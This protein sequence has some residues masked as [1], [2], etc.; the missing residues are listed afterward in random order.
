[1][2]AVT[3]TTPATPPDGEQFHSDTASHLG[4]ILDVEND[5]PLVPDGP[6]LLEDGAASSSSSSQQRA[7][8]PRPEGEQQTPRP[9]AQSESRAL[10]MSHQGVLQRPLAVD[11]RLKGNGPVSQKKKKASSD[12]K[13]GT[14]SS[15]K[16]APP[17]RHPKAA[18]TAPLSTG[19]SASKPAKPISGSRQPTTD[20]EKRI[21]KNFYIAL[22]K[23]VRKRKRAQLSQLRE[24]LF[25]AAAAAGVGL[26]KVEKDRDCI[27]LEEEQL[28]ELEAYIGQKYKKIR[29]F[30]EDC[31][32]WFQQDGGSSS[33]STAGGP[34]P[35]V[36]QEFR[37]PIA[38][39]LKSCDIFLSTDEDHGVEVEVSSLQ[40]LQLIPEPAR[41]DF[42]LVLVEQDHHSSAPADD[43]RDADAVATGVDVGETA[44]AQAL[45]VNE[46]ENAS[47]ARTTG[48]QGSAKPKAVAK[49]Q[50]Q[51]R[52]QEDEF[53]ENAPRR[54]G[55][56]Q[57]VEDGDEKDNQ[58]EN[59]I[60]KQKGRRK[61]RTKGSNKQ[62]LHIKE[63]QLSSV[64]DGASKYSG[65]GGGATSSSSKQAPG[66]SRGSSSGGA[67]VVEILTGGGKHLKHG[68]KLSG[69]RKTGGGYHDN[70]KQQQVIDPHY[71]WT[72]QTGADL[73]VTTT[74]G[75]EFAPNPYQFVDH[76]DINAADRST[77][78]SAHLLTPPYHD[79]NSGTT[80][81]AGPDAMGAYY[82]VPISS[83]AGSA[84]V[85]GASATAASG[86]VGGGG[87]APP[88]TTYYDTYNG[89]YYSYVNVGG[90]HVLV[91][92]RHDH[93]VQPR[94]TSTQ[95]RGPPNTGLF[96]DHTASQ[97]QQ[98]MH[99]NYP[100]LF[101]QGFQT[102]GGLMN[103]SSASSS[104]V[105]TNFRD[106]AVAST[107]QQ[108]RPQIPGSAS[109][110]AQQ[111]SNN[112]ARSSTSPATTTPSYLPHED[113]FY[114][115]A[116]HFQLPDV[117]EEADEEVPPPPPPPAFFS[118]S[119][120]ENLGQNIQRTS[121]A[122]TASTTARNKEVGG[123][124]SAASLKSRIPTVPPP[125][126]HLPVVAA[127]SEQDH[128]KFT[129]E[130]KNATATATGAN[131]RRPS[132][133]P[134]LLQ[135]RTGSRTSRTSNAKDYNT[136]SRSSGSATSEL[137][138]QDFDHTLKQ[139]LPPRRA[140]TVHEMVSTESRRTRD[141]PPE[142]KENEDDKG[143]GK[144]CSL[145]VKNDE[146]TNA[147]GSGLSPPSGKNQASK[148][149]WKSETGRGGHGGPEENTIKAQEVDPDGA[150]TSTSA[151]ALEE[152]EPEDTARVASQK[153]V[154]QHKG[155]PPLPENKQPRRHPSASSS[156]SSSSTSA[157]NVKPETSETTTTVKNKTS[158]S[159]AKNRKHC[160]LSANLDL[161]HHKVETTTRRNQEQQGQI[162]KLETEK[163]FLLTE[164]QQLKQQNE[165]LQLKLEVAGYNDARLSNQLRKMRVENVELKKRIAE[166]NQ[167]A[168]ET[169][170]KSLAD[171]NWWSLQT[172]RADSMDLSQVVATTNLGGGR[173]PT[174]GGGAGD[175]IK[176]V[177]EDSL[178]MSTSSTLQQPAGAGARQQ[179][180]SSGAVV[181]TSHQQ[182]STNNHLVHQH[183]PIA[184]PHTPVM[185]KNNH[186][187]V[188]GGGGPL[189]VQG[190]PGGE[191]L[192]SATHSSS[193][194]STGVAATSNSTNHPSSA[195]RSSTSSGNSNSLLSL[196]ANS[197]PP[198]HFDLNAG[199]VG[200][201][202]ANNLVSAGA[203]GGP[204]STSTVPT[205][206]SQGV[207][208]TI[209]TMDH[210]SLSMNTGLVQQAQE[211]QHQIIF[212]H[213]AIQSS[214]I[215][216]TQFDFRTAQN[217]S[218]TSTATFL[219]GQQT[220][221]FIPINHAAAGPGPGGAA[222]P[223]GPHNN[224]GV[225]TGTTMNV[226]QALY[227]NSNLQ[228]GTVSG[229][230]SGVV[231]PGA[232][233]SAANAA[234][235]TGSNP[236]HQ[237][238]GLL[239]LQRDDRIIIPQ[240]IV[241]QQKSQ[242]DPPMG[243]G[244][245][246]GGGTTTVQHHQ[247]PGATS[248]V[249]LR[250]TSV[251][252]GGGNNSNVGGRG[253]GPGGTGGQEPSQHQQVVVPQP[254]HQ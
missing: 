146:I 63:I 145:N 207:A 236:I 93:V 87:A 238:M 76:H 212:T 116:S 159:K 33:T 26:E 2:P 203:N 230:R 68:K 78:T 3:G 251:I 152:E 180:V 45:V 186:Q 233:S 102:S 32:C 150:R 79:I 127:S 185:N 29:H 71:L 34:R 153:L 182:T 187:N 121:S 188:A 208:A 199:L 47:G 44:Q 53:V 114:A 129:D 202:A 132:T 170:L 221:R 223:P 16:D 158:T 244:G 67:R 12:P 109:A 52:Q 6:T 217:S 120:R 224:F 17:L 195:G 61:E 164:N 40:A 82:P 60:Q 227:Q 240:G 156:S 111:F 89:G 125:E 7:V 246:A 59:G 173:G 80:V 117:E 179:L 196:L 143:D 200:G 190:G 112:T 115:A 4:G 15:S 64:G 25:F 137:Q 225:P 126:Q 253:G 92:H 48:A 8:G 216:I 30:L 176:E 193:S 234:A 157:G 219:S 197:S 198:P 94:T 55:A 101:H 211:Q 84:V 249:S 107:G 252:G 166:F 43:P 229:I 57:Q 72:T 167:K 50:T 108:Q 5:G 136:A 144:N 204:C 75:A 178:M 11:N 51:L 181:S 77:S 106:L 155:P 168:H 232:A 189:L 205:Q 97:Q 130:K 247:H 86:A 46:E 142:E 242:F 201:G 38:A 42:Y 169:Y 21:W 148:R 13:N 245:G 66:P 210:Q 35:V 248:N 83:T 184:P 99:S 1:M 250:G 141:H 113:L 124:P 27:I 95:A 58:D 213:P 73:P 54:E 231:T 175:T 139:R 220:P 172:L 49:G 147:T 31:L 122:R 149:R 206:S 24:A 154:E 165:E 91:D 104:H 162:E 191:I 36:K 37:K 100:P 19:T 103:H 194:T 134:E 226:A 241:Q 123:S 70:T 85:V 20:E 22:Q 218:G 39:E 118:S 56:K 96:V 128:M 10:P 161:L 228:S 14:T 119:S 215:P 135:H 140:K 131:K 90:Q 9:A 18:A 192:S 222:A 110:A 214:T 98:H 160:S 133:S 151:A 23:V 105:G 209:G 88:A 62:N 81:L 177:D 74:S 237:N 69:A 243:G 183:Q 171:A 254:Q 65:R 41:T 174:T 163:S 235:A 138:D 28:L 239:L